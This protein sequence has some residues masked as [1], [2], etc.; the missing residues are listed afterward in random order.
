[1]L[2]TARK[3]TGRTHLS[4]QH[5]QEEDLIEKMTKATV[6]DSEEQKELN[7]REP[8]E[9]E[10]TSDSNI[11]ELNALVSDIDKLNIKTQDADD[12]DEVLERGPTGGI[13]VMQPSINNMAHKNIPM[14]PM[15][16]DI[17]PQTY[18][19]QVGM[20]GNRR[21]LDDADAQPNKFF[22]PPTDYDFN[23]QLSQSF[24]F[25]NQQNFLGCYNGPNDLNQGIGQLNQAN[26]M[27]GQPNFAFGVDQAMTTTKM[28]S[29]TKMSGGTVQSPVSS[30][31]EMF[32]NNCIAD[33]LLAEIEGRPAIPT[34]TGNLPNF[35]PTTGQFT[36]NFDDK[37]FNSKSFK[38]M[39]R[40]SDPDSGL[41]SDT[42]S[43]WS[44]HAPSPSNS[45][46]TSPPSVES[47]CGRSPLH[48]SQPNQGGSPPKYPGVT[49]PGL[50][51]ATPSPANTSGYGSPGQPQFDDS[52]I[53][54]SELLD[55]ALAVIHDDM[56]QME[57]KRPA[58]DVRQQP[59]SHQP[60]P[61]NLSAPHVI[62][63]GQ[64]MPPVSMVPKPVMMSTNQITPMTTAMLPPQQLSFPVTCAS[65]TQ[66]QQII[67]LPQAQTTQPV[68]VLLPFQQKPVPPKKKTGTQ[69]KP[70]LPKIC[71]PP[72][73]SVTSGG[74]MTST[75]TSKTSVTM[76]NNKHVT[77][78]RVGIPSNS[79]AN[80]QNKLL[81]I[82]RRTVADIPRDDLT[83]SDDEG[84]TY[85]HIAVCKTDKYMVQALLERLH[86]E[87]LESLVDKE[88]HKR[89]TPLFLA[90][91]INQSVMVDMFIRF[92]ANVNSLAQNLSSDGS[93]TEVKSAIHVAAS[94]GSEY[95]RTLQELL[96]AKDIS[97]NIVNNYG[98]TALHCAILA[99]GKLKR[100]SQERIDSKEIIKT[101]IKKGADASAQDKKSG[102][103]P[104]MYAIEKKSPE[105]VDTIL[106]SVG[107]DKVK[108]VVKT[109]AFDGSSCLKIAEGLRGS[110]E[111]EIWNKLWNNLHTAASG[112]TSRMQFQIQPEY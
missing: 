75:C 70:I 28:V 31:T 12:D 26:Q 38:E 58:N 110:F 8:H 64:P 25:G 37:L 27:F 15:C 16:D 99:H 84:D 82:A 52:D 20:K 104:L 57:K 81:M 92:Q 29:S 6:T 42:G 30:G 79:P 3:D 44:E 98:Q 51:R 63:Q 36:N 90:V 45:T 4:D 49:S 101:L 53:Y 89:Q 108:N 39:R 13:A 102:K 68:C 32:A 93:T 19:N 66:P 107:P 80:Q 10:D 111:I 22:R 88:N 65:G 86:R 67:I 60:I 78:S 7:I 18:T 24:Q 41:D 17:P 96:K 47:G 56:I 14:G 76:S 48:E 35:A 33:G 62:N 74:M 94:H 43:P 103:T 97:I 59:L 50:Y 34:N 55:D 87:K 11:K 85:L 106:A 72:N 112:A 73:S 100:N 9:D 95:H 40:R 5:S 54:D 2:D 61:N 69:Y 83:R 1:M 23:Q 46:Y 91:F 109:Q 77:N 71:Q 105:L 21:T